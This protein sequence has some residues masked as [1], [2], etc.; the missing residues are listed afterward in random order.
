MS[1]NV[2]NIVTLAGV[3]FAGYY[4]WTHPL[5]PSGLGKGAAHAVTGT[6]QGIYE[7]GR[8][9]GNEIMHDFGVMD[10]NDLHKATAY[11][12]EGDAK[13]LQQANKHADAGDA[14]TLKLATKYTDQKV[15]PI[16]DELDKTQTHLDELAEKAGVTDQRVSDLSSHTVNRPNDWLNREE[17]LKRTRA[18]GDVLL[19]TYV[20]YTR[21]ETGH[22]PAGSLE[23]KMHTDANGATDKVTDEGRMYSCVAVQNYL[24]SDGWGN[25]DRHKAMLVVEQA[26][27]EGLRWAPSNDINPEITEQYHRD[28]NTM[29]NRNGYQTGGAHDVID[30]KGNWTDAGMLAAALD[31]RGLFGRNTRAAMSD[32]NWLQGGDSIREHRMDEERISDLRHLPTSAR[33]QRAAARDTGEVGGASAPICLPTWLTLGNEVCV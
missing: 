4:L 23:D 12:D 13:T 19:D 22:N 30:A 10:A 11:A 1:G 14:K 24:D 9:L 32:Y 6:F 16:K 29:L 20:D 2:L 27:R 5:T 7:G 17:W 26:T 8:D 25:V 18:G 28:L 15:K 31:P 21:C 3:G 33:H